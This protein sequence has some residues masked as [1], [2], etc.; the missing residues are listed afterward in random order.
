MTLAMEQ[1]I[2]AGLAEVKSEV[3]DIRT[4]VQTLHE[5]QGA[6][7]ATLE[8]VKANGERIAALERWRIEMAGMQKGVVLV[9]TL[10]WGGVTFLV[11]GGWSAIVSFFHFPGDHK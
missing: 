9:L 7:M 8:A 5:G 1:E 10:F 6:I 11:A 2:Y 4:D 3:K